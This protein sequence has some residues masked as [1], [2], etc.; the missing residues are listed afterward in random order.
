M[1]KE[2]IKERL[3]EDMCGDETQIYDHA[4]DKES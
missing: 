4:R 1:L 3:Q 2:V